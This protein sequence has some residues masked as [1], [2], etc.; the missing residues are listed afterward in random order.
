MAGQ[1]YCWVNGKQRGPYSAK[2][3][4]NGL[5]R[6]ILKPSDLVRSGEDES[7]LPLAE[8]PELQRTST[9]NTKP[10]RQSD[11][12]RKERSDVSRSKGTNGDVRESLE[13]SPKASKPSSATVGF[14]SKTDAPDEEISRHAAQALR[15]RRFAIL[16]LA[17]SIASV[18][19]A[20]AVIFSLMRQS[21]E[22]DGRE[23]SQAP[24]PIAVESQPPT[25]ALSAE[26]ED[27]PAP[28]EVEPLDPPPSDSMSRDGESVEITEPQLPP[29]S[30]APEDVSVS[31]DVVQLMDEPKGAESLADLVEQ[32]EP[33]IVRLEA[34]GGDRVALGTGFIIDSKG[35]IAT[36]LHVVEGANEVIAVFHDGAYQ[37]IAGFLSADP[38][39]DL[40][41][42]TLASAPQSDSHLVISS[43]S[44]R[45]G[46]NVFAIGFPEGLDLS[47]SDGIVSG[48]RLGKEIY[49]TM[50]DI[51]GIM[52]G[53]DPESEWIQ[54]TTPIS[55]GNSGGPLL[56]MEGEVVGINTW[57][58]TEGESLNFA[59]S[60]QHIV[61]L[62][63]NP[64][65]GA[66]P[67]T[68]LPQV[69]RPRVARVPVPKAPVNGGDPKAAEEK[70]Q[71]LIAVFE[72]IYEQRRILL[73][74]EEI[75]NA[76]IVEV[77]TDLEQA[78]AAHAR[79]TREAMSVSQ[80]AQFEKLDSPEW[81]RLRD[82]Y[83]ALEASAAGALS[84]CNGFRQMMAEAQAAHVRLT[85]ESDTLREEW[86]KLADPFGKWAAGEHQ[87]VL[88]ILTKWV[89]LDGRQPDPF[90]AR[91]LV[92]LQSN[93]FEEAFSDFNRAVEIQGELLSEAYAARGWASYRL[94]HGGQA[95]ADFG[96]ALRARGSR[97]WVHLYRG[98]VQWAEGKITQAE[99]D[100]KLATR[101]DYKSGQALCYQALLYAACDRPSVRNGPKA[102][103]L[104]KE[105]CERTDSKD[106]QCLYALAAAQAECEDFDAAIESITAAAE[107]APKEHSQI[108]LEL[109]QQYRSAEPLYLP[110][111]PPF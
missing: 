74:R 55:H 38:S 12:A 32:L 73:Q 76:K 11:R 62:L 106:W 77:R 84:Q 57:K 102:L 39:K 98:R 7:W 101:Q 28:T 31:Q 1:W 110:E 72:R 63:K 46:E 59:L 71:R 29:V 13:V 35:C 8:V 105:A 97:M 58:N 34:R 60:A 18:A 52:P 85:R 49:D 88:D 78:T 9:R 4:R 94:G 108:C 30:D 24:L 51:Q 95:M 104:A 99:D 53:L 41:L 42:L 79:F 89:V 86:L 70:R 19:V 40:I 64:V 111:G 90:I 22:N 67:L 47:L 37:Q 96:S 93:R 17:F 54:T 50:P 45:K 65:D 92:F 26:P 109:V 56:N 81:R 61:E 66:R 3:I 87:A 100:L 23:Y 83:N 14:D 68:E 107:L 25:A 69:E 91:G 33:L 48:R 16:S 103:E 15:W 2:A 6:G 82:R 5:Q 80:A 36:N 75:L 27:E 43:Q 20:T 10:R 21:G 44:C